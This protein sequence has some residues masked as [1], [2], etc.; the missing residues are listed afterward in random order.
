MNEY[1]H[2]RF[3]TVLG[4]VFLIACSIPAEY[5][6]AADVATEASPVLVELFTSEGCS[7]CP[8]ADAWLQQM[9]SSQPVSGVHL[10][11]LSEHVDYWNHDGWKDPYS[12]HL[13][14]D[15]QSDYVRALAL[16]SAYT[17]LVIVGGTTELHVNDAQQVARAFQNVVVVPKVLI[18]ISSI[19]FE[20]TNPATMRAHV[21]A[22]G[23]L[24]ERKG[25]VFVALALDHAESQVTH[26][27]NGGRHLTH[28][29]VAQE[30]TKIGRL[31]KGKNFT[32]DVRLRL[33]AGM[34]ASNTRVIIFVQESGP[35]KVLGAAVGKTEK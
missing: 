2:T 19:E 27:E 7:S 22:D 17:P 18:R 30:L 15:R 16:S 34:D 11:V 20:G 35:G 9:D 32:Q 12:S 24:A 33:K 14:T 28:V 31:E 23:N 10:I 26:G 3:I 4:I 8:P 5:A 6:R 21:E 13:I 29:A 1:L 25:D